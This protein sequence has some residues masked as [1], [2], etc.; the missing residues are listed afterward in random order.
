MSSAHT[1]PHLWPKRFNPLRRCGIRNTVLY[2]V[3][4]YK[5][6]RCHLYE[7][8]DINIA[9]VGQDVED[10][11]SFDV[12][13]QQLHRFGQEALR[14]TSCIVNDTACDAVNPLPSDHTRCDSIAPSC[15]DSGKRMRVAAY[16]ACAAVLFY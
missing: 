7:M 4:G 8:I 5:K 15:R 13:H 10:G 2:A 3:Q 9:H 11:F 12:L 6:C 1:E 16:I 14:M